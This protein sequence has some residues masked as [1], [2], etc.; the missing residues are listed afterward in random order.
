M[1]TAPLFALL[2]LALPAALQDEPTR[3]GPAEN[4]GVVVPTRQLLRPAG[5]SVAFGGRPVDLAVSPDGST[6]FAQDNR[7]LVAIDADSWSVRQELPFPDGGGSMHGIAVSKDGTKVWA[8]T[9]QTHLDEAAVAADGSL[10]WSRTI[11]LPGPDGE[12]SH[13]GGIALSNDETTAYVALSRNNSVGVVDLEA[14]TLTAE[15]PVGVAPFDLALSADGSTL[16]VSNWGGRRPEAGER[17]APSSGTPVLVDERGVAS[18]GT[19]G[20]VDL[21]E[22]RMVAELATGLHPSD[23]ILDRDRL[24]VANAN[25]DTVGIIDASTFAELASVLVRPHPDLP[26]GS[27]SNA[28]AISDDGRTLFVANGGNNAV[29]ALRLNDDRTDAQ[30]LGFLPTGWYPAALATAGGILYVANVKGVGSRAEPTREDGGRSVYAYL[31]TVDA[32]DHPADPARLAEATAMVIEDLRVPTLLRAR[33]RE[34]ARADVAPRP[35]PERLGE[36]SAFEHVV[37]V[38]KENRTYDQVFG[39]L[40]IGD[41]DPRLCIFGRE[42]SPNHHRLAEEF[43]LLDNFYCNGVLSADGHSW[44]TEGNVTDHLEKS[45]GGFTRSYTFGDDPLTYSS[46]GFIWDNA[47]LHGRS[48]RNYGEM[49]YAEPVPGDATFVQILDDYRNDAGAIRFTQ[50]IGVEPL[51]K[52]TC[53]DFP[54][55]N[56]RIPDVL[57]ADRFLDEL[58]DFEESGDFPDLVIIYLPEDHGSGTTPDLPTPAAHMADN[59]LA[60]GRIVEGLSKSRYWPTTCVFV[61]EDDPQNGFDHVD[62]HRS[63]CLVA[64]PY[65]SAVPSSASSTTRPPSSTPSSASSG[66][67]R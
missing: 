42:A 16:Y 36:P 26:F 44:A 50:T 63:I 33:E 54:G 62:G 30:I 9:A 31:G 43:V 37:Y 1:L 4:G 22:G 25:S 20:K 52:Y 41:G 32:I 56:M 14:G 24:Y 2:M 8:T 12:A 17:T 65:T 48:F 49:D 57:R 51:R 19:V 5:R 39:D 40:D 66:S 28:L 15:I 7:G 47:L 67:R 21:T 46:T 35:V 60:V 34:L 29:A 6:I 3:V 58:A 18:S 64:S 27:A 10:S 55:W 23:L 53:P 13:A 61:I 59:D 11:D 45:F 38:I